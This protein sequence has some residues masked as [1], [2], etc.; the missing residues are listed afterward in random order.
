MSTISDFFSNLFADWSERLSDTF[1]NFSE[2][3][4]P[5]F[6]D[7]QIKSF[8]LL[9]VLA[10]LAI[11]VVFIVLIKVKKI[12][13]TPKMIS[14]IGLAIALACILH[15]LRIYRFPQG[16][17]V[18]LGSMI[19]IFVIAFTY[20]KEVGLLT[21]FIFSL[22]NLFLDPYIVHPIQVLFDYTLPFTAMGIVAYFP[23]KKRIG[24]SVA[25]FLRFLCSFISGVVFFGMYA[26]EGMS[27][28]IYSLTVNASI[29]GAEAIVTLVLASIINIDKL[30][31][32]INSNSQS[33]SA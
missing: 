10:L 32:I 31:K 11:L 6:E 24:I 2:K 30:T 12:K 15:V 26:P 28:I 16:G 18:T 22:L 4:G 3:Y 1:G 14:R 17:S 23:N 8:L 19:P 5:I 7:P 33:Q 29:I 9:S 21:G 20:G 25:F 27:P 13:L